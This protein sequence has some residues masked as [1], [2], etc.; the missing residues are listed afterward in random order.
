MC[1]Y[2]WASLSKLQGFLLRIDLTQ[3]THTTLYLRSTYFLSL[4]GLELGS[5]GFQGAHST[6]RPLVLVR[7]EAHYINIYTNILPIYITKICTCQQLVNTPMQECGN[8]LQDLCRME[9]IFFYF[10]IFANEEGCVVFKFRV[11]YHVHIA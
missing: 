6:T 4:A 1:V 10:F 8:I 2:L 7:Y 9:I 11:K 3:C 5:S